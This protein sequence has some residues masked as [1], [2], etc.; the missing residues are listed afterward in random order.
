MKYCYSIDIG[1]TSIKYSL[2]DLAGRLLRSWTLRTNRAENGKYIVSDI[3]ITLL[4]DMDS[5]SIQK[6]ELIG[7]GLGVAGTVTANGLVTVAPNLGWRNYPVREKLQ[8]LTG[9][10]V[11]VL[12]DADAAALGEYAALTEPV[13]SMVF[14]TLG[15]GVGGGVIVDGNVI[16]GCQGAGGEIGHLHVEDRE[17]QPCGCGGSG[18][19]EQYSS[20]TG[21][22]RIC[23]KFLLRDKENRSVL[24]GQQELTAQT[25]FD[26]WKDGDEVAAKSVECMASYLGKACAMVACVVDPDLFVLG[27]GV[28]NAGA[29][30]LAAVEHYFF[31]YAYAGCK[32]NRFQLAILGEDAGMYGAARFVLQNKNQ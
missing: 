26:A 2:F 14:I 1:G 32:N 8:Q 3:A 17:T 10:P 24:H 16:A 9:I 23:R 4:A 25:I 13:H 30:L 15:T 27:G 7:I 11:F 21:V 22:V 29:P 31:K 5:E 28:A 19:L 20:A 6:E 18:C 12:N